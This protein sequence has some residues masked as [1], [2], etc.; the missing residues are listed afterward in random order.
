MPPRWRRGPQPTP[1]RPWPCWPTWLP[2]PTARWP[3][4]P[5]GW[6]AALRST[7]PGPGP[8]R[9][10]GSDASRPHGPTAAPAMS[11]STA[12]STGCSKPRL[13]DGVGGWRSCGFS[14]GSVPPPR[15]LSSWTGRGR[16]AA[17]GWPPPRWRPRPAPCE[18][19]SS[20]R[21]WPSATR[22]WPSSPP[23][24]T[25][26]R[27]RSSTTF[28]GCAATAPPTSPPRSTRPGP[29]SSAAPPAA[30]SRCCCRTA[31][32]PPGAIRWPR[33]DAST[34]CA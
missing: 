10:A 14:A 16:W 30:A 4:W 7:W 8:H 12:A 32:P 29:S 23:T 17:R 34:S 19:P 11:T 15:S 31:G 33:L 28:C 3:R 21:R 13:Q 22:S 18:R 25:V 24:A 9:R 27:P 2:P 5:P 26:R 20:G 1:I 6:R